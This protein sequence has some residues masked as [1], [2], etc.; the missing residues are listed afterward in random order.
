MK[1]KTGIVA[2][3]IAVGV[4]AIGG[5]TYSLWPG[6]GTKLIT[7]QYSAGSCGK[8]ACWT[9]DSPQANSGINVIVDGDTERLDAVKFTDKCTG[10]IDTLNVQTD[11]ADGVKIAGAHD[12]EISQGQVKCVDKLSILHQDGIQAM[13]GSHV[14]FHNM[15]VDCGRAGV[16][17]ID[18]EMFFN[19]SGSG[20][21]PPFDITCDGCFFGS[22]A[23]STVNIQNSDSSGVKNS[24][25]CPG[26][27]F[28]LRVGPE[29]KNPVDTPNTLGGDQCAN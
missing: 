27:F 7:Y 13:W 11:N 10:T 2:G 1:R 25:I 9:C 6:G 18:A 14:H 26:K 12:L 16:P 17:L 28:D 4:V 15:T 19:M 22:N 3:I 5:V 20:T 21:V 23:A 24:V 29:A 8:N